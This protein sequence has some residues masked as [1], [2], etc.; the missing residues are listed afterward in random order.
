MI[1]QSERHKKK[2]RIFSK[3]VSRILATESGS[4]GQEGRFLFVRI[5][6]ILINTFSYT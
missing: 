1:Q 3:I 6:D 4:P 5:C 2:S